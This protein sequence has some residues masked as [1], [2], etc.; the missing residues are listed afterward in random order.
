M[1]TLE[2]NLKE[3]TN[4]NTELT[5]ENLKLKEKITMLENEV[6]EIYCFKISLY[7]I[8]KQFFIRTRC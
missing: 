5:E 3:L 7:Y 4:K 1:Q 2:D 8:K 6:S